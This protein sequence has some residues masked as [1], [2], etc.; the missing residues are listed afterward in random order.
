MARAG[1]CMGYAEV[2]IRVICGDDEFAVSNALNA[3]LDAITTPDLREANVTVFESAS[4]QLIEVMDTARAYPFMADRRAI[5]VKGMLGPLESSGNRA[6]GGWDGLGKVI[7]RDGFSIVNELIFVDFQPLRLSNANLKPLAAI[8]NVERHTKPKRGDLERWIRERALSHGVDLTSRA[9]GR[10]VVLAGDDT[11]RIDSEL[12]KLAL[13]ADGRRMDVGDVE[14]MV[15]DAHSEGIFR[16]I[17]AVIDRQTRAAVNGLSNLIRNGESIEG[18]LFLLARQLRMLL[19]ASE[20]MSRGVAKQEIGNRLNLRFGWLLDK[21]TR[22]AGKTGYNRLA[23]MHR[24]VLEVDV[25]TK[26]GKVDRKLAIEMLIA[27]LATG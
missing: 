12:L 25:L 24:D 19:V 17:D 8:A 26:T 27:K 5:V 22:Q 16:V 18:I 2:M 15:S 7:A 6:R 3:R 20:L 11:R 4:T 9:M 13:Y 14:L 21:T 10:F 23:A 1:W